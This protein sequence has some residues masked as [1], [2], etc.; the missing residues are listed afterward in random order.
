MLE[1]TKIDLQKSELYPSSPFCT[2]FYLL[3]L[4]SPPRETDQNQNNPAR[5]FGMPTF[6]PRLLH[7]GE[8]STHARK[9]EALL[10]H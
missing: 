9:R 2:P 10:R 5:N 8:H 6:N 3:L 7:D 4:Q 1:I